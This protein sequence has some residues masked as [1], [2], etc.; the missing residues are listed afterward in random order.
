MSD[1]KVVRNSSGRDISVEYGGSTYR[2]NNATDTE[3]ASDLADVAQYRHGNEGLLIV[4]AKPYEAAY[5]QKFQ[6]PNDDFVTND[7]GV[8]ERHRASAHSRT[9]TS[10]ESVHPTGATVPTV[11]VPGAAGP[12]V[13]AAIEANRAAAA[14]ERAGKKGSPKSAAARFRCPSDGY[15]T[16]D[17]ALYE[18]H[19]ATAHG[20]SEQARKDA[21]S[22]ALPKG[23]R[24]KKAETARR[25]KGKTPAEKKAIKAEVK[26]EARLDK[27]SAKK[28]R[29]EKA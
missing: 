8:Y 28:A 7:R 19:L 27:E 29:K 5:E 23:K 20:L 22:R 12:D 6:C 16:D 26:H 9:A 25:L 11:P 3:V 18:N 1:T 2:F 24:T 17:Q 13:A 15:Y 10:E 4:T 21:E 14:G